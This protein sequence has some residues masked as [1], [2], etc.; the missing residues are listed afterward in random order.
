MSKVYPRPLVRQL[1]CLK[2]PLDFSNLNKI[3]PE[4]KLLAREKILKRQDATNNLLLTNEYLTILEDFTLKKSTSVTSLTSSTSS[5][6]SQSV[7]VR[8]PRTSTLLEILSKFLEDT[9]N[10]KPELVINCSLMEYDTYI[11]RDTE[12][13]VLVYLKQL[14]D[15][16]YT[17]VGGGICPSDANLYPYDKDPQIKAFRVKVK[18]AMPMG[19]FQRDD[20]LDPEELAFWRLF[21]TL[22]CYNF[23]SNI[24]IYI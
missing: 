1:A 20:T 11:M 23:I 13:A 2:L 12:I 16:L 24:N 8:T 7:E 6:S 3:S 21:S 19:A 14:N 22:Y 18:W 10:D 15:E 17:R 4:K 5:K 9:N